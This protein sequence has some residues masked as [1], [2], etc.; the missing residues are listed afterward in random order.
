MVRYTGVHS[1][2][3][4]A[5]SCQRA[6]KQQ[7]NAFPLQRLS[8]FINPS[9]DYYKEH[10]PSLDKHYDKAAPQHRPLTCVGVCELYQSVG[11]G[12]LV[13]AQLW[14]GNLTDH[15]KPIRFLHLHL[16]ILQQLVIQSVRNVKLGGR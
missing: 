14:N 6:I 16:D 12:R 7:S 9:N 11:S 5:N 10:Q 15:S 3:L 8:A 1:A 2:W 4:P 13:I